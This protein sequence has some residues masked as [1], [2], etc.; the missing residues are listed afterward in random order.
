MRRHYTSP[1]GEIMVGSGG[2]VL[3]GPG[4]MVVG[5]FVRKISIIF[6]EPGGRGGL[7]QTSVLKGQDAGS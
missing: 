7:V 3:E 1:V 5:G 2:Y 6:F 4:K